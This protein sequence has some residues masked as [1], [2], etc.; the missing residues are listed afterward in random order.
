MKRAI[1]V[2]LLLILALSLAGCESP[3]TTLNTRCCPTT[4][5]PLRSTVFDTPQHQALTQYAGIASI[6][7]NQTWYYRRNDLTPSVTAGYATDQSEQ[8]VTV[9]RNRNSTQ[10]DDYNQTTYSRRVQSVTW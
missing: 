2:C 1:I 6:P 3:R 10:N 7:E 4:S 5:R 9:T 8:R